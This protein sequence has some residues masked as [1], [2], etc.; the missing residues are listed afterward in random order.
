MAESGEFNHNMKQQ[1]LFQSIESL[2][3]NNMNPCTLDLIKAF[4]C[5]IL[6]FF[7]KNI[8]G[9]NPTRRSLWNEHQVK[10]VKTCLGTNL[11]RLFAWEGLGGKN[12]LGKFYFVQGG[13]K[14]P[15][16]VGLNQIKFLWLKLQ[17]KTWKQTY[18]D[19]SS[20]I[21]FNSK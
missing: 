17:Q 6:L 9:I 14:R 7:T 15:L 19:F 3:S 16:L 8:F 18:I 21:N 2:N 12:N 1:L 20:F 4:L 11:T 5:G 13:F 10:P